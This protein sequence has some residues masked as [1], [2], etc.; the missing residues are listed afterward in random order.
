MATRWDHLT[1]EELIGRLE[2]AE[3]DAKRLTEQAELWR[4]Q[5]EGRDDEAP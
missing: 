2:A 4:A 1:R 3:D 5:A